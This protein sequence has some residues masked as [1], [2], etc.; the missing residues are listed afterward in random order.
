[1]RVRRR[2]TVSGMLALALLGTA[3]A[4]PT[5]DSDESADGGTVVIARSGDID[6][7]DPHLATAFQTIEALELVYDT[8][9]EL[10][11]DLTVQPGLAESWEYSEDG[12][13]LTMQLREDVI[14][15]DGDTF[16]SADVKASIERILDE[17]TGAVVRTNLLSIA[18]VQTPDE[19]TVALE[20]S[21]AD[22][23]LPSA[24]TSVNTAIVSEAALEAGT[25]DTE[26]NGTGP[27]VFDD[28]RQGETLVLGANQDYWGDGPF[29]EG[30][31]IRVVPEESSILAGMRAGQ[32]QLGILGDPAVVDQVDDELTVERTAELGYF[33]L[34]LNSERAPLDNKQVRQAI[35]CGIDRQ[36]VIDAAAFG[37][38]EPTGPLATPYDTG[39]F[40]GLPCDQT[41]PYL[42]R[43]LLTDA[44]VGDGFSIETIVI[45]GENEA[46]INVAQS[47]QAQLAES[48]VDLQL[49]PLETNV[50]VD[51]WLA[52]DFDSALSANGSS[53]DP[54]ITYAKYFTSTGNFQN[55]AKFTTPELDQ[56]FA[57]G[58]A[59]TDQDERIEIYGEI[60]RTL[61]DASPWVWLYSG[62]KY[63]VLQ[64]EL[65]DFVPTP[66]G[67]LKSLRQVHLGS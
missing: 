38:G 13:T 62:F 41:D 43:Q 31:E 18:D 42:A 27:F 15:H 53:V 36:Q 58:K 56:L 12:L 66:T 3:C 19:Q 11:P 49:V 24:F 61:L 6:N 55:V 39:V 47:L 34:F 30:V 50:Y 37:E 20:L 33:P 2:S 60:A 9:F 48:G 54:Q 28:W 21:E 26:P 64:P 51:R 1:M 44:G 59:S 29:V 14:F 22:G 17:A 16:D 5:Q 52:A 57:D 63:Q 25:V 67:S 32:F 40:D 35:A 23:T 8:L 45:Q 46:A 65:T 10:D 4:P 7:L